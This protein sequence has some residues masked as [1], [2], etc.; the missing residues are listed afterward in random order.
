MI[1]TT[2]ETVP[3]L[4]NSPKVGDLLALL[5][6]WDAKPRE[7]N[8]LVLVSMGVLATETAEAKFWQDFTRMMQEFRRRYNGQL[9]ELSLEDRAVLVK[10]TEFNQVSMLSDAKLELLRLIQEYFPDQFGML[11]QSRLIRTIDL[12]TKLKNALRFLERYVVEEQK[13]QQAVRKKFRRLNEQDIERVVEV[14]QQIGGHKFAQA[15]IRE[16][17]IAQIQPGMPAQELM[18]EYFVAMDALKGHVFTDVELRGSGNIFNQL[19]ITLDRLLLD[20]YS[21]ANPDGA[22]CSINLNVESVFTKSFERFLTESCGNKLANLA[23]E[24]RQANVLQQYDE[25]AVAA[26]L[27][28]SKGGAI[29]VDAIFPDTVGIV[30]MRR[31]RAN[32]AKIFWRQGAEQIL[33]GFAKDIE[34]MQKTGT[35]VVLARVDDEVGIEVGHDL[36][37]TL[38][39]GFGVDDMLKRGGF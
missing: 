35:R 11:D 26:E 33:P 39:Q 29:A 4:D 14:N 25:Y 5:K 30:N 2:A 21:D 15:F 37:I 7:H 24:F 8:S 20:A 13:Q 22:N 17:K 32:I 10:I 38:F 36:G 12:R 28:S 27:I 19:T 18:S 1:V 6:D 31:L 34:E 23:F 9:F 3:K 16:Q